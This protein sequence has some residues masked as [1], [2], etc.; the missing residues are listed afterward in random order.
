LPVRVGPASACL[1]YSEGII[2]NAA[3]GGCQFAPGSGS[4]AAKSFAKS[5]ERAMG[6]RRIGRKRRL[7]RERPSERLG[8]H[9]AVEL[10]LSRFLSPLGH[11]CHA[12]GVEINDAAIQSVVRPSFRLCVVGMV[13][14]RHETRLRPI[15]GSKEL[16]MQCTYALFSL[17]I[18]VVER[19]SNRAIEMAEFRPA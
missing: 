2:L 10:V 15:G 4:R 19:N 1:D 9:H 6:L 18:A 3:S 5:A 12:P 13:I 7:R 11:P 17:S 14:L 16:R 8:Y